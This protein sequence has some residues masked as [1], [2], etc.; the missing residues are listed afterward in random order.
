[1]INEECK[2]CP[3]KE[4]CTGVDDESFECGLRSELYG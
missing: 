3:I 4:H 2:T 1:M